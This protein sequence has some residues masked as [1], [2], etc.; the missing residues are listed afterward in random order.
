MIRVSISS[1]LVTLATVG[2]LHTPAH[3]QIRGS[4]LGVVSQ[5]IDGTTLTLDVSA[6]EAIS[7]EYRGPDGTLF[8]S[9][10]RGAE[11]SGG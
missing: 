5:T 10:S 6:D 4:E 11:C 1:F 2:V 8:G 3:A 7:V 9:G